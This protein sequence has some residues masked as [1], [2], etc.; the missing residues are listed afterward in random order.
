[1]G[2]GRMIEARN[3]KRC[4]DGEGIDLEI[5][6]KKWGWVPFTAIKEDPEKTGQELWKRAQA[7]E[8][9]RVAPLVET[10]EGKSDEPEQVNT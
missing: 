2:E 3:P 9:G 1:M 7:G 10:E 6:H 4:Q 8:F 5:N